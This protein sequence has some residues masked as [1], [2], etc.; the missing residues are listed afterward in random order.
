[1]VKNKRSVGIWVYGIAFLILGLVY[2]IATIPFLLRIIQ[3]TSNDFINS[4]FAGFM[5]AAFIF[6][7][8][9]I[10]IIL[11]KQHLLILIISTLLVFTSI[12]VKI[13]CNPIMSIKILSTPPLI[14][15]FI[16]FIYF[17]TRPKVKER[18]K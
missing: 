2:L 15:F 12:F 8:L 6:L 10:F 3:N 17:I 1:V 14:L 13:W 9:G 18:F 16:S 11:C 7:L 5:T 4:V